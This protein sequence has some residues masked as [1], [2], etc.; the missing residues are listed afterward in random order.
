M[1][2][3]NYA[4]ALLQSFIRY[5]EYANEYVYTYTLLSFSRPLRII[6]LISSNQI[7]I[8]EYDIVISNHTAPRIF[9]YKT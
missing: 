2:Y 8:P 1:M 9:L 5:Q 3:V 6:P 7:V 4:S